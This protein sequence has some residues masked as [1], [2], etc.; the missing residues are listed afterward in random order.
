M[1]ILP[2]L[3]VALLSAPAVA[4]AQ[5][6]GLPIINSGVPSG[7]TVAADVGFP[8]DQLGGGT[9]Y[10]ASATVGFGILGLGAQVVRHAWGGEGVDG[11]TSVGGTAAVRVFGGPLVPF[12]VHLQAGYA[13]WDFQ[14]D[15]IVGLTQTRGTASV[16]FAATI[17]VPAFAIKPWIAPRIQR[18][19]TEGNGFTEYGVSGGIELGFLNGMTIR[20]AY[21]RTWLDRNG[22]TAQ[23]GIWS[24][25]LGWGL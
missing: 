3:L 25:G 13:R 20:T 17:P 8:D 18:T 4:T 7:V 1:R 23:P 22:F 11:T 15:D 19:D 12:R 21:D 24:V 10:G 5:G 9:A 2:A 16:G 6:A 14:I